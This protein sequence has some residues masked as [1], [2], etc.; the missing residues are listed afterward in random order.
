MAA[1]WAGQ[2]SCRVYSLHKR[3]AYT[4]VR[5]ENVPVTSIAF[6]IYGG[7]LAVGTAQN[8][9]ISS[10]KNWKKS[11]CTLR[12]FENASI[13]FTNFDGSGRKIFVASKSH[14]EVK[15]LSLD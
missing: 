8:M 4:E 3:F 1:S 10:Y 12:P 2:D 5:Q 15:T 9:L 11:L 6:D 13:D 14:G 7:Y